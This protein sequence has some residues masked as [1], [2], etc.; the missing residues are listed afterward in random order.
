M[1]MGVPL[2]SPRNTNLM[3]LLAY[4]YTY[5]ECV[6]Y[7]NFFS[8]FEYPDCAMMKDGKQADGRRMR[9]LRAGVED[10]YL[11]FNSA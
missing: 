4:E 8:G 9:E 10:D 2:C 6:S 5:W 7:L 11:A 1:G 3:P